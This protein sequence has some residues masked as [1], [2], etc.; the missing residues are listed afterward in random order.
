M[1]KITRR[2]LIKAID[3]S[4]GIK[5]EICRRMKINYSYL[6]EFLKR[7]EN[8]EYNKLIELESEKMLD[9]GENVL[10]RQVMDGSL[11]ATKFYLATKGKE[12]GYTK[13]Q[14]IVVQGSINQGISE[15]ELKKQLEDMETDE[16]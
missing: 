15:D 16:D 10:F 1:A 5:A 14:D 8:E 4:M 3:G 11:P 6:W 2:K 13:K 7:P 9:V 12:R